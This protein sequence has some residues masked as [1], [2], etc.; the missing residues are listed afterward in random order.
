[1]D[2][3]KLTVKQQKLMS[4]ILSGL[5]IVDA[6]K[7]AKLS[8][9]YAQ[10]LH[11][12][13]E[14]PYFRAELDRRKLDQQERLLV[15][16]PDRSKEALLRRWEEF[17]KACQ[18]RKE[19]NGA[20]SPDLTNWGRSLIE[21]GKLMGYYV[22]KAEVLSK[23]EEAYEIDPDDLTDEEFEVWAAYEEMRERKAKAPEAAGRGGETAPQGA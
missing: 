5:S 15:D 2:K 16:S 9:S 22:T 23:S 1:M 18:S 10:N 7:R 20:L 12:G 13:T 19:E 17:R 14:K 3:V 21:E 6:A 8:V 4:G 11:A